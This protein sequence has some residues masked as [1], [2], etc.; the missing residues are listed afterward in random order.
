[1]SGAPYE[2][3]VQ[4]PLNTVAMLG[5]PERRETKIKMD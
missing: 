4:Q 2:E 3:N 1:M 5:P